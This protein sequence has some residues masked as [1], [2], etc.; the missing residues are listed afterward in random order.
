[1]EKK[2]LIGVM[3]LVDDERDSYWMLPG[4][5]EGIIAAGGLPVMLPLTSDGRLL[6]QAAEEC[7]GFL[8]TGGPDVSPEIY[9]EKPKAETL[10][11]RKRDDM[12]LI[13]LDNILKLD[14]PILGICRGIQLLNAALGGNLWQDI[15]SE[16]PSEI[17]HHMKSPY[18]IP[19]HSVELVKDSPIHRLLKTDVLPVNSY[20]HQAVKSVAPCLSVMA[21]ASDGLCEAVYMPHKKFVWAV[22]W[23][24]EFSFRSDENSFLIF[25]AFVDSA[26]GKL[27]I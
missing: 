13:L 10:A 19:I 1:M 5:M 3:P 6:R 23:H 26:V 14:K 16:N 15:P 25:K 7:D 17:E 12:E 18:D 8:Y 20:H 27:R 9:G 24:P 22:Q 21:K 4:Y 11:C 2:P